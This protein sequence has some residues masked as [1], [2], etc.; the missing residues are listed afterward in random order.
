MGVVSAITSFLPSIH[1]G[2]LAVH[3]TSAPKD[4]S[5]VWLWVATLGMI[6]V[7]SAVV[8]KNAKRSH[9]D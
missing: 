5:V 1:A 7:T 3:E 8:F 4:V 6:A 2:L 9:Q